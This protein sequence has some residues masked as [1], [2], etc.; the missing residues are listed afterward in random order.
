[1]LNNNTKVYKF[2]YENNLKKILCYFIQLM[3]NLSVIVL[4]FIIYFM[5]SQMILT[6]I[7]NETIVNIFSIFITILLI[8]LS[9]FFMCFT[10]FPRKVVL[11]ENYIKIQKNAMN[12]FVGK[13]WFSDI[14]PYSS[15][16]SCSILYREIANKNPAFI[17]QQ[18]YPCTF[19]NSN[20][21]VKITDKYGESY[22]I[23]IKN[24]NGFVEEVNKKREIQEDAC[25]NEE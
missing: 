9:L 23:S 14:I 12:F 4:L 16:I 5:I 18:T 3:A 25:T 24:S 15:I 17:R 19:Y 1:M 11:N 6:N 22:Y 2:D 21:L 20:S 10:F 13:K 7:S 8:I